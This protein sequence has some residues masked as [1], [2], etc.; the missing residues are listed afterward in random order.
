M[1]GLKNM[2]IMVAHVN[3]RDLQFIAAL[4][5]AGTIKSVIDKCYP[6]SETVAAMKFLE[7]VHARG[8]VV[9]KV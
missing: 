7:A 2:G 9:I 6:L 1:T 4:L 5:E 3:Q 8:K